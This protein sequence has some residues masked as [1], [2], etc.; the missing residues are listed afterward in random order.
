MR[1]LILSDTHFGYG[2]GTE[3]ERDAFDAARSAVAEP[4]DLV[5]LAGDVFDMRVPSPETFAAALELLVPLKL[6]HQP[7]AGSGLRQGVA[8]LAAAPKELPALARMG[9]PVIAVAG[10]HERRA[11]GLVNPVEALERAGLL[12]HLHGQA[13]TIQK[14]EE[15]VVIH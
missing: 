5:L 4:A 10:N 9:I 8:K 7:D 14:G 6:A 12:V 2:S 3:R 15:K 11:K 1:I 13:A